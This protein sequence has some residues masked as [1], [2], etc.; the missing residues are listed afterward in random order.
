MRYLV[1]GCAG[2]VGSTLLD[3][4]LADGHDVVGIDDMSTG[5]EEFLS[6]ARANRRFVFVKGDLRD[7]Q[8]SL[9]AAARCDAIFHLAAN[10]D[11]RYGTEHPTRDLEQN[12][13]VT[14]NVLE[15]ARRN[16]VRDFVFSSTG[17]VYGEAPVIP[18]PEDAPIPVQTSLYGA[19]KMAAEGFVEAYA[20]GFG[21]RALIFRFVSLLG[22]RYTHGH[23]VDFYAQLREHPDALRVLGNGLQRKSYL[24]VGDCIDAMLTALRASQGKVGVY[25]LGTDEYCAVNDSIGW[26]CE[27]LGVRPRI[28]YTGGDRGWIG[29]NPFIFLDCARIRALGWRP[30]MPIRDAVVRTV[31][32]L[33]A[34]PR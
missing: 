25:N 12:T 31:R 11:V 19:S 30:T 18:T 15:A 2:F 23:V 21:I 6:E 22:E 24:Y 1:T 5:R 9:G 32:W 33:E 14:V 13:V 10:A 4:L 16:G 29:D 28:E 17:S 34:Q 7:P 27:T 8:V 26:I 20:E 3:R